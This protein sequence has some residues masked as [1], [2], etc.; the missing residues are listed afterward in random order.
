M[1][2]IVCYDPEEDRYEVEPDNPSYDGPVS[3]ISDPDYV[4][5]VEA[6][7]E[8]EAVAAASFEVELDGDNISSLLEL[9]S[10]FDRS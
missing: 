4:Y 3:N 8:D 7:T 6:E 10:S 9:D 5:H 1:K 2:Y